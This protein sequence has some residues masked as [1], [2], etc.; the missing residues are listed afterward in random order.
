MTK[1]LVPL[2][3]L[4]G[5]VFAPVLHAQDAPDSAPTALLDAYVAEALASNLALQQEAL[6]LDAA[7]Y[8]LDA[9]RRSFFP[10]L[11]VEARFSRAGGG[12]TIDLPLGDLLN[13]AYGTL[14]DLLAAQGEAPSFPTLSNESIP[15]LREQEQETRLRVVQPLYQPR[16]NAAVRLSQHLVASQEAEVEAL[17]Q[18]LV[19][20]VKVAY[21]QYLQAERATAIF[22]AA[23]DL[24]TEN[25]RT[26]ERLRRNDRVLADAVL[27]ARAE[28]FAVEQQQ[29][30]AAADRDRARSYVNF[31]L[32]RALGTPL[33]RIEAETLP[34]PDAAPTMSV[35]PAVLVSAEASVADD[36]AFDAALAAMQDAAV[37]QRRELAQLDAAIEA[38]QANVSLSRASY[39]PSVAL[40]VDGGIQGEGYGFTGDA[41]YYLASVVLSWKLFDFGAD[42]ARVREAQVAVERTRVAR[43]EAAQQ[44]RLQV[45]DAYDAVRVA[46]ASLTTAE[47]RVAAASE[48]F[49]LT[50]RRVAE[51]QVNQVAFVDARTALTSAELNLN[52]TRYALLARLADLEFAVGSAVLE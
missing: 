49:R 45:Q 35:Q 18:Q 47:E 20:D 31:L 16:L 48:G 19:R 12:R 51:G 21:F 25:L 24:V 23:G 10:T 1:K 13:P 30:E 50:Q 38:Q 39:L 29:A 22:A 34:L 6:D 33:E 37:A 32:N 46:R 44:I 7:R 11:S 14:N 17:R 40:A 43:T 27:R 9:A 8:A 15:F 3:A 28:T 42:R 4:A 52:V 2:L 41:P 5:L 26:T 36:P